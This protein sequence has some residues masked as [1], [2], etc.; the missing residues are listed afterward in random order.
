MYKIKVDEGRAT[1][2][3]MEFIDLFNVED[4]IVTK[5][6]E[7]DDDEDDDYPFEKAWIF[8]QSLIDR[9]PNVWEHDI[10]WLDVEVA[11]NGD[12]LLFKY[13]SDC[14]YVA[15]LLDHYVFGTNETHTGEY[16]R[17]EDERSYEVDANTGW[18]YIDFD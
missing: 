14:N 5:S 7:P 16:N 6:P 8:I 3:E 18:Y 4:E 9:L 2:R 12:E 10:E 15:D 1:E 11:T 13:E 17:E